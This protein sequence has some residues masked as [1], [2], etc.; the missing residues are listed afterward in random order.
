MEEDDWEKTAFCTTEELY[1]P[2]QGYVLWPLK[3]PCHISAMQLT[4]CVLAYSGHSVSHTWR[5]RLKKSMY[6]KHIIRAIIVEVAV[7]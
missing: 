7:L 5:S 2:V 6:N 1:I 4:L 3:S